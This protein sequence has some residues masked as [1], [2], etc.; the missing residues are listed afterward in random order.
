M[1]T[2]EKTTTDE[3]M[4][5]YERLPIRTKLAMYYLIMLGQTHLLPGGK[6]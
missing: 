6:S 5:L 3:I 4:A 2:K 1:S